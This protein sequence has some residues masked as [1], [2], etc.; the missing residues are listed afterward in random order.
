MLAGQGVKS[1]NPDYLELI[2]AYQSN[3]ITREQLEQNV[4]KV[5]R[6]MINV[7]GIAP[8]KEASNAERDFSIYKILIISGGIVVIILLLLVVIKKIQLKFKKIT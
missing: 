3:I 2:A 6:L 5:I 8:D 4:E 1:A 7:S